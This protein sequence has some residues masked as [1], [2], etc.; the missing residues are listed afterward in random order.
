[1]ITKMIAKRTTRLR[2]G[3][4]RVLPETFRLQ[5]YLCA[6]FNNSSS[7]GTSNT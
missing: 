5:P 7:S 2:D 6:F 4:F 1:M 3:S